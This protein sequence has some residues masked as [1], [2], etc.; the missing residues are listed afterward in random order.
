MGRDVCDFLTSMT[1]HVR[2]FTHQGLS[3]RPVAMRAVGGDAASLLSFWWPPS[4][5]SPACPRS[6]PVGP[7]WP[8]GWHPLTSTSPC[9]L[10]SLARV[11]TCG[12]CGCTAPRGPG[13]LPFRPWRFAPGRTMLPA[14][15]QRLPPLPGFAFLIF[16]SSSKRLLG[17]VDVTLSHLTRQGILFLSVLENVTW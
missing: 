5:P 7:G 3:E 16:T 8:A 1:R 14:L 13:R 17:H 2:S 6:R 10:A 11:D 9:P 4:R 12:R 15:P